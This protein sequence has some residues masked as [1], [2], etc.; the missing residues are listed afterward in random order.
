[1]FL[2]PAWAFLIRWSLANGESM[3]DGFA[4]HGAPRNNDHNGD[5]E[6]ETV[7]LMAL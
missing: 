1:V 2:I 3:P 5:N 6:E 7:T 4:H